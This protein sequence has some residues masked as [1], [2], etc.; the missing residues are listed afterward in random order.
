LPDLPRPNER[1]PE[2]ASI[3]DAIFPPTVPGQD[4]QSPVEPRLDLREP[5]APD[6][7]APTQSPALGDTA[8]TGTIIAFGCI[9][10]TVFLIVVGIVIILLLQVF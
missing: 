7:A 1:S 2:P 10:A 4:P 6:A 9:G 8:G 3:A 5:E